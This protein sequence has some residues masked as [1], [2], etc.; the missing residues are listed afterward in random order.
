MAPAFAARYSLPEPHSCVVASRPAKGRPR[1][2][3]GLVVRSRA[4]NEDFVGLHRHFRHHAAG[5]LRQLVDATQIRAN[6]LDPP[7]EMI[8]AESGVE[9][10]RGE[11][12]GGELDGHLEGR[13][14]PIGAVLRVNAPSELIEFVAGWL[15][16][17]RRRFCCELSEASVEFTH[18]G[19]DTRVS[20]DLP[21]G[22]L[23]H[24]LQSLSALDLSADAGVGIF[25]DLVNTEAGSDAPQSPMPRR[26]VREE[27]LEST[28]HEF[29]AG[30]EGG[31]RS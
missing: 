16:D 19:C 28:P 6:G 5:C 23:D 8:G 24:E 20:D 4:G 18:Q 2:C 13:V 7:I 15:W 27:V 30:G 26:V 11:S 21:A 1:S 9:K 25:D 22:S 14:A 3:V 31:F 12:T 17:L 29:R 10:M